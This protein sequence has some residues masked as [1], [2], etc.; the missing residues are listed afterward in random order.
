MEFI[1]RFIDRIR[2]KLN[3]NIMRKSVVAALMV[4]ALLGLLVVTISLF[5]PIYERAVLITAII[6]PVLSVPVGIFMGIKR[7]IDD[8]AAAVYIDGL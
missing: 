6:P 7:R 4:G 8:K 3:R 1:Y 2:I 5:V